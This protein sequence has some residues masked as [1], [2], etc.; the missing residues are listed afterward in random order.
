M[1]C[2]TPVAG[3]QLRSDDLLAWARQC[4]A[5]AMTLDGL[6]WRRLAETF[7]REAGVRMAEVPLGHP[8]DRE[9]VRWAMCLAENLSAQERAGDCRDVLIAALALADACF[10]PDD[11]DVLTL[12][13]R[14]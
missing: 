14:L 6:G 1:C 5:L 9:R 10:G 11:P 2:G 13:S 7:H 3:K 8:C 4:H 12:R